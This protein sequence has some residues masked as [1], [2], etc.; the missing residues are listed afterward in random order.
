MSAP[1]DQV[2]TSYAAAA[3]RGDGRRRPEFLDSRP[4]PS[5]RTFTPSSSRRL[6]LSQS[7][8]REDQS[9]AFNRLIQRAEAIVDRLRQREAEFTKV[10]RLAEHVNR[11]L[12]LDEVLDRLY[13][14]AK[15]A[16]PYNRIGL[17]LIDAARGMLVARSARSDRP[18]S[19][20]SGYEAPLT[21]STLQQVI[22]TRQP[23]IINDLE[24]Y[25]R[26]KPESKSTRLIVREGMRSSL[27][28]PL[29][30]Q[31]TPV[32]FVFFSSVRPGTYSAAHVGLFQQ[33]AGQL[34]AIVE[35]SRLYGELASQNTVIEKQN[36]AMTRDLDMARQV[37]QALVP[38]VAPQVPGLE[39]AFG[40]RAR[41]PG[42]GRRAGYHPAGRRPGVLL[43]GRRNGARRPGGAGDV[44]GQGGALCGRA[45]WT[46]ARQ[47]AVERQRRR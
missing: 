16:I 34:S 28:C 42:R 19:L 11:G 10:M 39:I 30:V 18:L 45:S 17:S 21:G 14:E 9:A 43:R 38:R 25:L 7:R 35:K 1:G 5:R 29:V 4:V 36:E 31:D 32:G 22:E 12:T 8:G 3:D 13:E 23:R 15:D 40:V 26:A 44:G 47:R 24:A 33:I 37:Q 6:H 41:R 2:D 20:Q 46:H 27:T